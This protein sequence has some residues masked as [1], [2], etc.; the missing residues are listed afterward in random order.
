V[1]PLRTTAADRATT[2][3]TDEEGPLRLVALVLL[4]LVVANLG[5]VTLVTRLR[6]DW[7][8]F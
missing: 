2:G 7:T 3:A 8:A 6:R 5:F 4:L 1:I